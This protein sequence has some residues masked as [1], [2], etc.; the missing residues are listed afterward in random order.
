MATPVP[1]LSFRDILRIHAVRQLWIGQLVSVFG[2]FLAIYA[3]FAVVSFRMHGTATQVSG[4]LIAYILP[5]TFISP[6]AGVFVDRWDVK[7]TMVASDLTRGGLVAMLPFAHNV[8]HIY[9][10]LFCISVVGSFFMPAQGVT[11]RTVVP[12]EG[13]MTANALLQQVFYGMQIISP[14]IAGALV[15]AFGAA[16][17]F[18]IDVA[19]FAFSAAMISTIT[20]HRETAAALRGIKSVFTETSAG[21]K[22][23]FSHAGISFVVTAMAAGMFAIRCFGALI[24]VYVRDVLHAGTSLFGVLGSMVGVGMIAGTQV[25]HRAGRGRSHAHIVVA[26]LAGV[27]LSIF[28]LAAVGTT[29]AAAVGMIGIG[30]CAAFLIVPSQTLLQ[31]ETPP[32][33]LGRVSGSMVSV[34]FTAQIIAMSIVGPVAQQTGIRNLYF[35]SAVMVGMIAVAGYM[36]LKKMRPPAASAAGA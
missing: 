17:C 34:M 9:I 20:V 7:R 15:A 36:R 25:V 31:E 4:I 3:V 28:G 11:I 16:S 8:W 14:A 1:S 32:E 6:V 29:V 30:V 5:F 18:W 27:A 19:T 24:A 2:D 13:L 10:I 12:R 21:V 33:L 22:F 23:I 35:L 26:G